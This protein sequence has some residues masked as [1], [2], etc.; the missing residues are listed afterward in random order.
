MAEVGSR[1]DRGRSAIPVIVLAVAALAAAA[2]LA[3]VALR[4]PSAPRSLQDR[5]RQVALTLRCPVCQDLSV[6]D[7]PSPLASQMRGII[8]DDLARGMSAQ[9][10]QQRFVDQY[11][12]WILLAPPPRGIDLVAWIIPALLLLSGIALAWL[13]VRRWTRA[14]GQ[15]GAPREDPEA[16]RPPATSSADEALLERAMSVMRESE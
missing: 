11:G 7:S 9:S 14:G 3:V 15:R 16:K 8:A 12:Q 2:A 10:I 6:A 5:V 1:R 13:A 4:G